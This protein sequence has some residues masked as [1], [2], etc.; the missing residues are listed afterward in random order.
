MNLAEIIDKWTE[1]LNRVKLE[2]Q[3]INI[4]H[5]NRKKSIMEWYKGCEMRKILGRNEIDTGIVR[6]YRSLN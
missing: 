3:K 4:H 2:F 1:G 5:T 6:L